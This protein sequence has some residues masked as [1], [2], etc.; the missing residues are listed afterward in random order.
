MVKEKI[1]LLIVEDNPIMCDILENY[2]FLKEDIFVCGKAC[3]GEEAVTKI[4]NLWPDIVLLDIVM[5]KMDG[6]SV[7]KHLR[8]HPPDKKPKI[9]VVS[10][11]GQETVTSEALSLGAS[12]YIIKPY[13]LD[14]LAQRVHLV[15]A[16]DLPLKMSEPGTKNKEIDALIG[17]TMISLGL[18]TNMLG[19]KYIAKAI[20]I[21][22]EERQS[23]SIVKQVYAAIAE[24]NATTVECVES[25]IRKTVEKAH[26]QN[27][28]E[29]KKFM[30]FGG[31][32]TDKK[33][34]N[35]SFLTL[36]AEKI[37]LEN[38]MAS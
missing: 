24:E 26:W 15:L 8:E 37:R 3:D 17:K 33:P 11:I 38:F 13:N 1:K 14:D 34:T 2:F 30:A 18:P 35:G 7:L 22:L 12:Y 28:D 27:N 19:Y 36:M 20:K 32:R 21:L 16:E 31:A 10:A 5:P 4:Q 23:F 25:A 9:I 6:L 29:F